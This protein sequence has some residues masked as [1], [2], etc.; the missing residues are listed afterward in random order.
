[1]SPSEDL[2]KDAETEEESAPILEEAHSHPIIVFKLQTTKSWIEGTEECRFTYAKVSNDDPKVGSQD[3][4]TDYHQD[5]LQIVK[6]CALRYVDCD[7][8]SWVEHASWDLLGEKYPHKQVEAHCK[9]CVREIVTQH[10]QCSANEFVKADVES[11]HDCE[12]CDSDALGPTT[13]T[14]SR[15]FH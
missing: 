10:K 1:M 13:T 7:C 15:V 11:V 5:Q 3:L 4:E 9:A 14:S 8:H 6:Q 12:G 2:A